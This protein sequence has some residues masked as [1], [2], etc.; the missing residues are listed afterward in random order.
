MNCIHQRLQE[1]V[2]SGSKEGSDK[3][4]AKKKKE[5]WAGWNKGK[6]EGKPR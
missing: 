1:E 2:V 6:S 3:E 5:V 4:Q